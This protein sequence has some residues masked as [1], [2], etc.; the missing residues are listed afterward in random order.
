MFLKVIWTCWKAK[1]GRVRFNVSA[2]VGTRLQDNREAQQ[3]P[4][5]SSG[6]SGSGGDEECSVLQSQS[7]RSCAA[8]CYTPQYINIETVW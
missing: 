4:H 1:E 3:D 5:S 8:E 6:S 2:V 7:G